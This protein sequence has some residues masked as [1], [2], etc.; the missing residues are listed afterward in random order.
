[1]GSL[2]K[3]SM[4][5]DSLLDRLIEGDEKFGKFPMSPEEAATLITSELLSDLSKERQDRIRFLIEEWAS[6]RETM[7]VSSAIESCCYGT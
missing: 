7:V 6:E 5:V 3:K 4:S 2:E 1:M